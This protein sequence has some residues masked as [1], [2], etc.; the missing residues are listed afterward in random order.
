[1]SLAAM[2]MAGLDGIDAQLHNGAHNYGPFDV[3]IAKQSKE[4]RSKIVGLP[5]SLYDALD[6]LSADREFLTRGSV[7][8]NAF[9]DRWIEG[10]RANESLEI[11]TRPHPYEYHLYLD[12]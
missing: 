8:S 6:A 1:V 12:V 11:A 4:F 10:K 5:R 7:F 9:I 3:D 2:L